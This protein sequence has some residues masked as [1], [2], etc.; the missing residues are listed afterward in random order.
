MLPI[1]QRCGE[2]LERWHK[3]IRKMREPVLRERASFLLTRCVPDSVKAFFQLIRL[4]QLWK[5]VRPGGKRQLPSFIT[6][7]SPPQQHRAIMQ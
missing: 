5:R 6:I 4:R 3:V 7:A 2:R 1:L